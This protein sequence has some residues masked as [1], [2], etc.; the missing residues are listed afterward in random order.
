MSTGIKP[1]PSHEANVAGVLSPKAQAGNFSEVNLCNDPTLASIAAD[2]PG[3]TAPAGLSLGTC[4]S[5]GATVVT[6]VPSSA[7]NPITSKLVSLYFPQK[8]PDSNVN[9]VNGQLYSYS[10]TLPGFD[11]TQMGDLRID[12]D[13]N[14]S[15]RI[16]GV[17]HGSTEDNAASAVSFPYTGLGLNQYVRHNSVLSL[18]YTRIFTPNLVNEARGGYNIEN[19]YYGDNTTVSSFLT[20]IGF[21][22]ADLAAY[23][24]IIGTGSIGLLGNPNIS[25]GGGVAGMGDDARSSDRNLTQHLATFGDTF[26]W[27]K[28]RHAIKFGADFVRNEAL[29]SFAA[30]RDTPQSTMSYNGSGL[31]GYTN[32]LLG[33]A[34]HKFTYVYLPRPPMDVSNWETAYYAQD[35]FKVSSRLNLNLGFRYDRFTPYVDKNDIMANFDPNYRNAVTGQ[36]GEYIIPSAKTL[37]YL[38]S[39]EQ[40]LPPN[41]IGYVLAADSGLGIGRGLIRTD[42]FDFGP[43]FGWAYRLNDKRVLRGGYGLFYPTSA[44][45]QVRD[46]LSTNS[47][48]AE[49]TYQAT[50]ANPITPWPTSSTSTAG[51]T[52]IAGGTLIGFNNYPTAEFVPVGIKN[53][54]LMEW[55]ATFEQQLARQTTVRVS[56]IGAA[57]QGLIMQNDLDMIPAND[58]PF[59]TTQGDSDY[60]G[61]QPQP[62]SGLYNSCD[63][64]NDGDCAYS[65]ADDARVTFPVLGDFVQGAGNRGKSMTN[66]LQFQAERKEKGLT[67]SASYT[68]L[69]QKSSAGDAGEASLGHRQLR[70]V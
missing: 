19:A 55:N 22:S 4:G 46:P 53:P 6:G 40:G 16:Y 45:H 2:S 42:R 29:D 26:S 43:R 20:S 23:G 34:P 54:R 10:E 12:H 39:S 60:I 50:G 15:N 27:Q 35:D 49:L 33:N 13:F 3:G 36:V 11:R 24:A 38:M 21:S 65:Y 5:S 9:P 47:F 14:D 56:Y 61:N 7:Q 30:L 64:Y 62:Y 25:F 58:N 67:F 18:S 51:G 31:T 41:G 68:Y 48:N 17:Y 37:Q 1:V 70:P 63:P 44:A 59:G 69:D 57:Q 52:P 8:I 28:G 66:S 32:F